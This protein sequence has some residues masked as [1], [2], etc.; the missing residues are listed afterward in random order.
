M[1]LYTLL[2]YHMPHTLNLSAFSLFKAFSE[3]A[4]TYE[5]T[6]A[7]MIYLVGERPSVS[8]PAEKPGV[9]FGYC[10]GPNHPVH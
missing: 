7:D 3:K 2:L 1:E 9:S 6:Y 5:S 8:H 10:G 4:K